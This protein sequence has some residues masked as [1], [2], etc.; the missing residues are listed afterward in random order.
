[1]KTYKSKI[2]YG[3]LI[4]VLVLMLGVMLTPLLSGGSA[5][6]VYTMAAIIGPVTL[7][8]LHLFYHTSYR[9]TDKHELE[10]RCGLLYRSVVK[11]AEIK[12][13]AETRNIMA[14]PAASLDRL[15]LK[16]GKW[17]SVIISPKDKPGFVKTLLEINPSI[18]HQRT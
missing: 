12:S 8:I 7:F 4:P 11:I 16:Y 18:E 1:M 17:D 13:I 10:I 9:I 6:S 14:S 3:I 5:S 2:S 15:E